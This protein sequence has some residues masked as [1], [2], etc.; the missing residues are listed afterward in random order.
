[1]TFYPDC[2]QPSVCSRMVPH[3]I[4]NV[5][6]ILLS[7]GCC[8]SLN[9]LP[10]SRMVDLRSDTVT[11]PSAAMR[12]AM[13]EAEVGDDVFGDDPTV[14]LLENKL[15]TMFGKEGALF[16]PS[17]TM[18]NLAATM[19]WCGKRG[20]EM[21]LGDSSHMFLYEQGGVSQLDRKSVV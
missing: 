19:S 2:A 8:Q 18:S 20:S 16:F 1:M 5:I 12:T 6:M 15:A 17:G 7:S 11:R 3:I 13:F 21:I 14:H 9:I 4:R 10:T